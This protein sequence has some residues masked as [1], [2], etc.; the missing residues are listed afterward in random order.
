MKRK[1]IRDLNL[2]MT[3]I[4]DEQGNLIV[5][6]KGLAIRLMLGEMRFG[7]GNMDILIRGLV[8]MCEWYEMDNEW[9]IYWEDSVYDIDDRTGVEREDGK[10]P[11][12]G[13]FSEGVEE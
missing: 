10:Y 1:S 5:N 2:K 6:P 11:G 8:E 7:T 13:R 9:L 4:E 12:Y 3:S